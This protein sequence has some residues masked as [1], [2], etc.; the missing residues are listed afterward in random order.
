VP[1]VPARRHPTIPPT[2]ARGTYQAD[3]FQLTAKQA[4]WRGQACRWKGWPL[5]EPDRR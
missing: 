2:P 4:S 3:D 1:L 5:I